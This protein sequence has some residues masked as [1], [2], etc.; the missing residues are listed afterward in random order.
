MVSPAL[1]HF[2]DRM[3]HKKPTFLLCASA[4]KDSLQGMGITLLLIDVRC[5]AC[6]PCSLSQNNPVNLTQRLV[7]HC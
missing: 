1:S 3:G 6:T 4:C 7:L 5:L 2:F